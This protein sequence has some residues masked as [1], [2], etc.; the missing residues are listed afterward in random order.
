MLD[1]SA[2][3][4]RIARQMVAA[5]GHNPKKSEVQP[6]LSLISNFGF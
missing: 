6:N 2:N 5:L 3:Q 4:I 1:P